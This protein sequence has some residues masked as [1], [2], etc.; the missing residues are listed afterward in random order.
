MSG[1]TCPRQ[2]CGREIHPHSVACPSC[3]QL[4]PLSI[5]VDIEACLRRGTAW[6]AD[7]LWQRAYECAM[8][9]LAL[10]VIESASARGVTAAAVSRRMRRAALTRWR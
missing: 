9:A 5:R 8:R 1:S 3:Y 2:G 10:T 6:T 7:P 4:V